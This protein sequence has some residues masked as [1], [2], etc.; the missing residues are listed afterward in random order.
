MWNTADGLP[1]WIRPCSF[2]V[3]EQKRWL[4]RTS[5][6]E[7]QSGCSSPARSDSAGYA[8]LFNGAVLL[9]LTG[10]LDTYNNENHVHKHADSEE[11]GEKADGV[12]DCWAH[13]KDHLS[14]ILALRPGGAK[15]ADPW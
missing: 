7:L 14:A 5:S 6:S 2:A 8:S 3:T 15:S 11:R 4:C 1:T 13:C 10:N 12:T 9:A